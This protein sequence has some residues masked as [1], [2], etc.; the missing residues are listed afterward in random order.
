MLLALS[1]NGDSVGVYKQLA[2]IQEL[3]KVTS[4]EWEGR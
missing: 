3:E 1:R 2:V 4:G